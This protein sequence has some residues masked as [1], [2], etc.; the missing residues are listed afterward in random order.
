[1]VCKQEK[2]RI[3]E[4]WYVKKKEKGFKKDGMSTRRRKE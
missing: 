1:M 3:E 4:G 2:E